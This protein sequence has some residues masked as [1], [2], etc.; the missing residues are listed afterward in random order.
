M[1]S[2]LPKRRRFFTAGRES[3]VGPPLR[4]GNTGGLA[5]LEKHCGPMDTHVVSKARLEQWSSFAVSTM[6]RHSGRWRKRVCRVFSAMAT[7]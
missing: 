7:D 3:N 4:V 6:G 1:V 2:V 5:A